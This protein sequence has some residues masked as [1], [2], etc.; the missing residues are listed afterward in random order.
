MT[1][2]RRP[3]D[4]KTEKLL[5]RVGYTA[6]KQ[7]GVKGNGIAFPDLKVEKC[8]LSPTSDRVAYTPTIPKPKP[9]IPEGFFIGNSHKQ[10]LELMS[11]R[12]LEYGGG[13]KT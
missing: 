8:G 3:V 1:R 6:L 9:D 11:I 5:K 13:K 12:H 7:K 10:G 4:P 2:A